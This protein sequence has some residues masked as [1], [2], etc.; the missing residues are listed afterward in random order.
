MNTSMS[1]DQKEFAMRNV[2]MD[3]IKRM[4]AD[5]E[6]NI[7]G[8]SYFALDERVK[9]VQSDW[10]KF[11][12]KNLA[13]ACL[14]KGEEIDMAKFNEENEQIER[15]YLEMKAKIRTKMAELEKKE[16]MANQAA[17]AA[18]KDI[19]IVNLGKSIDSNEAESENKMQV[20]MASAITQQKLNEKQA[21]VVEI[22]KFGGISEWAKFQAE[23]NAKLISNSELS[24]EEKY[25]ALAKACSGTKSES[26]VCQLA[27]NDFEKAFNK[28]NWMFG[29][30]YKQ[31]QYFIH[32]L[33][34]L[35]NLNGSN[36]Y[37]T[38]SL[39]KR[40]E[41]IIVNLKQN[42]GENCEQWI[43]FVVIGKMDA[44]MR[45]AWER[46]IKIQAQSWASAENGHSANDYIPDWQAVKLFLEGEAELQLQD[47]SSVT[48][49]TLAIQSSSK[50][51]NQSYS[52][53]AQANPS[54][55]T[56]NQYKQ[57]RTN[58]H[59]DC[60]ERHPIHKC[61]VI[62]AMDLSQ[63]RKYMADE[64]ICT[65]C[66]WSSHPGKDCVDPLANRFCLRCSPDKTKHNSLLCP[67][68]FEKARKK[69]AIVTPMYSTPIW[70]EDEWN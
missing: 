46:Q 35:P 67:V 47:F 39:V 24:N 10:H 43:A 53:V 7:D 16:N 63:R 62:L 40:V 37:E 14:E 55:S 51:Q 32:M 23:I 21:V 15:L 44:E 6:Q 64:K 68:S 38:I 12:A 28:L 59:C 57:K 1:K 56:G 25:Q 70:K 20:A 31:A 26:V 19:G 5:I 2:F 60:S 33:W 42:L 9:K 50:S 3:T 61:D 66:L 54:K 13:I 45:L 58:N 36:G 48:G 34:N 4:Q 18:T 27:D 52:S 65:Q 22:V 29:S 11:E 41:D 17:F 30:K 69:E 49:D 8:Y